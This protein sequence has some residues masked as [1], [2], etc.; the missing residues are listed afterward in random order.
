MQVMLEFPNLQMKNIAYFD[1]LGHGFAVDLRGVGLI[2]CIRMPASA[3][4]DSATRLYA[5]SR[6]PGRRMRNRALDAI[7]GG[8]DGAGVSWID[9]NLARLASL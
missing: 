5:G 2:A 3:L 7:V 6:P 4:G 1:C 8:R 9:S